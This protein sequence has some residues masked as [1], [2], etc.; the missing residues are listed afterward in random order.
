MRAQHARVTAE[1]LNLAWFVS[2]GTFGDYNGAAAIP[3]PAGTVLSTDPNTNELGTSVTYATLEDVT[4]P[5][6]GA[7]FYFSAR[8]QNIGTASNVGDN[9]IRRHNFTNYVDSVNNTLKVVN[10]YPVLNG[11]DDEQ[12]DI[13]RF[14]LASHYN[15]LLQNNETRMKLISLEIP[16]IINTRVEPGYF[17]IGTAGV[18]ALGAEN[19]ATGALVNTLQDRLNFW[20]PPGGELLATTATEVTFDFEIEVR[21]TRSLSNNEIVRLRNEINRAFL[22]YFRTTTIGAVVDLSLLIDAIQRRL[23]NVASIGQRGGSKV[24]KR[25]YVRKGFAGGATDERSTMVANT[26]ALANDE[27]PRL[28]TLTIEIV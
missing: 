10:F 14:R 25:V 17:G 27:F 20:K 11:T 5:A 6:G 23:T 22:D 9:V 7:V 2:S 19:Q 24:F 16:G 28:G 26:Y 15:R 3:V 8:A 1:E 18:F 21:P 4:L 12:D 13:Y